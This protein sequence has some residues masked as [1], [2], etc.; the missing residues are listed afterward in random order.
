MH[1]ENSLYEFDKSLLYARTLSSELA[2]S[3]LFLFS[4]FCN[5]W[6]FVVTLTQ[7]NAYRLLFKFTFILTMLTW[8]LKPKMSSTVILKTA[9][10]RKI[11]KVRFY[12]RHNGADNCVEGLSKE[13]PHIRSGLALL[14]LR[15]RARD[16]AV[17]PDCPSGLNR[18]SDW[19]MAGRGSRKQRAA[20]KNKVEISPYRASWVGTVRGDGL[21]PS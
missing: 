11:L 2:L 6:P 12:S 16:S 8:S 13:P 15:W 19:P 4:K 1:F 21:E 20:R 17:I 5:K 7:D 10:N 3:I 14:S 9:E 18:K